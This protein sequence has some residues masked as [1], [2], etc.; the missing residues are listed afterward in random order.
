MVGSTTR[1]VYTTRDLRRSN[2]GTTAIL[3]SQYGHVQ[4]VLEWLGCYAKCAV[5]IPKILFV[6]AKPGGG[7]VHNKHKLVWKYL[8]SA[9][10]TNYS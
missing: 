4:H 9:T 5:D 1:Y 8:S 3:S 2:E 7:E 6:S 10:E